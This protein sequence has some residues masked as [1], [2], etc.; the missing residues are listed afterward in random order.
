MFSITVLLFAVINGI[1]LTTAVKS[2][3]ILSKW[4]ILRRMKEDNK[5]NTCSYF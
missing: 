2:C 1:F 3:C 5:L 4:S